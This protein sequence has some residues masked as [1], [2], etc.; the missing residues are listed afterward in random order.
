MQGR[1][2]DLEKWV[3]EQEEIFTSL[4]WEY[5]YSY[6]DFNMFPGAQFEYSYAGEG[7]LTFYVLEIH[8]EVSGQAYTLT[9]LAVGDAY[10]TYM[11]DVQEI[12]DSFTVILVDTVEILE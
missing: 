12:I 7:G 10:E 11:G 3:E 6:T 2:A 8:T 1:E 4:G 9:Y 5:D